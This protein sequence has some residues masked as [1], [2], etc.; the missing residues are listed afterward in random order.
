MDIAV[1]GAVTVCND[2][3]RVCVIVSV[4]VWVCVCLYWVQHVS[5]RAGHLQ[6]T[7]PPPVGRG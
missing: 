2:C 3:R 1:L 7:A 5:G 4:I 6:W